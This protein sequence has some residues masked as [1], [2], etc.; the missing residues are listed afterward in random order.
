MSDKDMPMLMTEENKEN[1]GDL[2]SIDKGVQAQDKRCI[3]FQQLHQPRILGVSSEFTFQ[4]FKREIERT[5][6]KCDM[7]GSEK[8]ELVWNSIAPSLKRVKITCIRKELQ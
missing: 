1:N 6:Q 4:D 5:G 7:S 2:Q 3:F 8:I